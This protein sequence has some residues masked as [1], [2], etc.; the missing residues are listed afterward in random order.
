MA[1]AIIKQ[2]KDWIY[3]NGQHIESND[4]TVYPVTRSKAVYMNDGKTTVED[5]IGDLMDSNSTIQ[6]SNGTITETLQSGN[7]VTTTFSG[8][9]IT[10]KC[11]KSDGSDVYTKTTAFTDGKITT[12]T[13]WAEG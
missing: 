2:L 3:I 10:E 12:E 4:V 11:V 8:N 7:V 5:A 13:V 1:G 9:V 6:F